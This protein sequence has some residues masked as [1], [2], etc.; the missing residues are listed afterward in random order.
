M[1]NLYL[2]VIALILLPVVYFSSCAKVEENNVERPTVSNV[3]FNE[4][5][6]IV[7]RDASNVRRVILFNDSSK[8][9][10]P[11][12]TLVPGK[13]L[14]VSADLHAEGKLSSFIVRGLLTYKSKKGYSDSIFKLI[15]VGQN[16]YS[17]K[18]D[19]T[20]YRNRLFLIP[21][22]IRDASRNVI[23]DGNIVRRPDTL[24]LD[25]EKSHELMTILMDRFGNVSDSVK[26]TR[27]VKFIRRKDL[28][29]AMQK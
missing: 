29:K 16:I 22:T 6:T 14:Y 7:Y 10:L 3:R 19:S 8:I 17:N 4:S 25:A 27:S 2:Y 11:V 5:D 15:G 24:Y 9:R 21:D 26:E 1:R 18:T 13:W 23:E 28:I 12:D 20:V